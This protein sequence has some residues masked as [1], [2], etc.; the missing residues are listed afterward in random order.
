MVYA[1]VRVGGRSRSRI[2]A[3]S[4][5]IFMVCMCVCVC[6]CASAA[7]VVHPR[8]RRE[9]A[10]AHLRGAGARLDARRGR[11][12][13]ARR[14]RRP[15]D[16]QR[17]VAAALIDGDLLAERTRD[18][19][20]ALRRRCRRDQGRAELLLFCCVA[21]PSGVVCAAVPPGQP[22]EPTV[23]G[24]PTTSKQV[25]KFLART[26]ATTF[27]KM[28]SSSGGVD[29]MAGNALYMNLSRPAMQAAGYVTDTTAPQLTSFDLDVSEV[30]ARIGGHTA[31]AVQWFIC[32]RTAAASGGRVRTGAQPLSSRV[33]MHDPHHG[34]M[35]DRDATHR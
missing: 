2:E 9:R 29:D 30:S 11:L 25:A 19:A 15:R 21:R 18:H 5:S 1:C 17:D 31:V 12:P 24:R 22:A 27:L 33:E 16:R 13:A 7:A 35:R 34:G 26:D 32:E 6:A 20:L 10:R 8:P 14:R 3:H 4:I 28:S 23:C